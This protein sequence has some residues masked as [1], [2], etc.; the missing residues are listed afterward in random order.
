MEAAVRQTGAVPA[1][2]LAHGGKLWAGASRDLAE[3]VATAGHREKAS[4]RDLGRALAL[5]INAGLTVSATL[6]AAHLAG[7]RVFSTGGIGGVHAG[8]GETGDISADLL[9]L[10]RTPLVTVCS[11]AKSVLDIPRTLEFLE[12]AGVPVYS[13]RTEHFPAFYLR[14]SGA[15]SI[16]VKSVGD[17]AAIARAQW[18]VGYEAGLVIGNPIPETAAL[19]AES[20]DRWLADAQQAALHHRVKGKDVTPFL[21]AAVAQSSEGRTVEA[22][23]S[24]LESNAHLAGEIAAALTS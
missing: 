5:H 16:A 14:D 20:W 18:D 7:I 19:P 9:Q 8:V 6:Y 11:G 21:L 24:L 1:T 23:L 22:N 13:F 15:I 2:C 10:S 4:V 12:M 3:E 17:I